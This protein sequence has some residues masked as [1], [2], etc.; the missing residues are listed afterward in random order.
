MFGKLNWNK[1]KSWTGHACS[2]SSD[3][4]TKGGAESA[5]SAEVSRGLHPTPGMRGILHEPVPPQHVCLLHHDLGLLENESA[6][7]LRVY[8]DPINQGTGDCCLF[9][10]SLLF[11][12]LL[13]IPIL[14]KLLLKITLM[15]SSVSF[16]LFLSFPL[17]H[18]SFV[19]CAVPSTNQSHQLHHC[20]L[21]D[22]YKGKSKPASPTT[23]DVQHSVNHL[24]AFRTTPKPQSTETA[25]QST[26]LVHINILIPLTHWEALSSRPKDSSGDS[27]GKVLY[28][29]CPHWTHATFS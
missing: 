15:L 11:S 6:V 27:W 13:F 26:A 25:W 5:G 23:W 21:T 7:W 14:R 24:L 3:H 8:T 22:L 17:L 12:A 18:F 16:T 2:L 19:F 10:I 20:L 28:P 9:F 4:E 1:S 29:F